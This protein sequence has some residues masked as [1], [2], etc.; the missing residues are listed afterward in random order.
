MLLVCLFIYFKELHGPLTP[1]VWTVRKRY[2]MSTLYAIFTFGAIWKVIP[3]PIHTIKIIEISS[4]SSELFKKI[5]FCLNTRYTPNYYMVVS[6]V[7]N[8]KHKTRL[9]PLKVW[10]KD[11]IEKIHVHKNCREIFITLAPG[12]LRTE[13]FSVRWRP[14]GSNILLMFWI[15]DR[16]MAWPILVH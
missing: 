16:D 2:G 10:T 9:N 8:A 5:D 13:A 12:I 6:L 14:P 7:N 1:V 11:Q 15:K 4:W 3:L